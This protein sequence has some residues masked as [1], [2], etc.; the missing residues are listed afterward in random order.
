MQRRGSC[1]CGAVRF[2]I[3][4]PMRAVVACHCRQCRKT[5][6]HYAAY[7][8]VPAAA[9][10]L[11]SED[12]LRWYRSSE[13]A[14]RGFCGQC[15]ASLFWRR[16]EAETISVAAGALDE[17]TGLRLAGHIFTDDAGDYYTLA[18]G[19]PAHEGSAGGAF[20]DERS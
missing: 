1:L 18:D 3:D 16:H 4:G 6:G 5:H 8:A 17:P 7:S 15:G 20:D 13:Q 12:S 11:E 10:T 19:L 9:L 14:E 2:H